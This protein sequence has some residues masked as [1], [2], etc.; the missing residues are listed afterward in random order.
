MLSYGLALE[1]LLAL[2]CG[3]F[4]L[5][6][7]Y[8][9]LFILALTINAFTMGTTTLVTFLL[10]VRPQSFYAILLTC[11]FLDSESPAAARTVELLGSWDNFAKSYS[12]KRDLRK[13]S[14]FWSGCYSFKDI[15]CDGD[16]NNLSQK[17]SG[18]LKM[19]GTY[20]YYVSIPA[21]Y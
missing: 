14:C 21:N 1:P 8:R 5:S 2:T 11:G 12:M 16:L 17:R 10:Y 19:G 6:R 20:W 7:T 15:I 9:W 3:I 18:G 4:E 13:G